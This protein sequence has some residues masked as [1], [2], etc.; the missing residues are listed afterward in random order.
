MGVDYDYELNNGWDKWQNV[1]LMGMKEIKDDL[2]VVHATQT[3]QGTDIAVIKTQLQKD[4]DLEPRVQALETQAVT[5]VEIK[6]ER[7]WI[8]GTVIAVVSSVI[9]PILVVVLTGIVT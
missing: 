3:A 4:E 2:K 1:V 9:V 5:K 7:R 6:S 8:V